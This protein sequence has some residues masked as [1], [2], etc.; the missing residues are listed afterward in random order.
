MGRN[1]D[2]CQS[3]P[4]GCEDC[5]LRNTYHDCDYEHKASIEE[6]EEL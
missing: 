2:P 6:L 4:E 5:L 1:Y 3:I